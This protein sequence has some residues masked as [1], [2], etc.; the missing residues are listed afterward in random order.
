M[1]AI[2]EILMFGMDSELNSQVA[3]TFNRLSDDE[4]RQ[5]IRKILSNS[6]KNVD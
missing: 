2:G 3:S 6:Q 4:L 1:F 5:E